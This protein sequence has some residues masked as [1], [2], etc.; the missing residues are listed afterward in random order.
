MN[1]NKTNIEF[2]IVLIIGVILILIYLSVS[3]V[4]FNLR[5]GDWTVLSRLCAVLS[6]FSIG[7][8]IAK[9][10]YK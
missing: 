10:L 4:E 6:F 3:F 5:V 9:N 1:K 8:L 2:I 7:G